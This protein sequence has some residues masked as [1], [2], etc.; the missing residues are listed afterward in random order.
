GKH[1]S[2]N[3]STSAYG[4]ILVE[5]QDLNGKPIPGFTLGDCSPV[6]GDTIDRL[7]T[8]KSGSDLSSIEGKTVRLHVEMNDADLYSFHF[9]N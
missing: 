8:W 9:H 5:L 4:T 7:V 3:F 6:F 1:L 2:L